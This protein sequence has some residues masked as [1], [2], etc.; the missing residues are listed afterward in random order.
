MGVVPTC[1]AP[2]QDKR[3][4]EKHTHT[5]RDGAPLGEQ[6][7]RGACFAS[8]RTVGWLSGN[9]STCRF[10][11]INSHLQPN[12]PRRIHPQRAIGSGQQCCLDIRTVDSRPRPGPGQGQGHHPPSHLH[13]ASP[14]PEQKA[15]QPNLGR[16]NACNKLREGSQGKSLGYFGRS[17]SALLRQIPISP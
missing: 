17:Q 9:L 8:R 6:T 1:K 5:R 10:L 4:R 15:W 12:K 14:S 2:R 11:Q 13:S 16:K 7:R 3:Q